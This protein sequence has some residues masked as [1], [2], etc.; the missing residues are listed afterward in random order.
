MLLLWGYELRIDFSWPMSIQHC[1][2]KK[3]IGRIV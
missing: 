2:E 1:A 3:A